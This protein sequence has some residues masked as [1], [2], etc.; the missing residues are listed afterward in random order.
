MCNNAKNFYVDLQ[1]TTCAG[2]VLSSACKISGKATPD[3]R[4]SGHSFFE[5]IALMVFLIGVFAIG[6]RWCVDNEVGCDSGGEVVA[7]AVVVGVLH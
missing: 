2:L 1:L 3:D 5:A 6:T 4:I 7:V